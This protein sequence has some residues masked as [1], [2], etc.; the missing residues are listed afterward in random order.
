MVHIID[1]ICGRQR[2]PLPDSLRSLLDTFIAGGGRLLLSTDHFS[3]IDPAWAKQNLHAS[4]YAA[5][6]T[7]S[8]KI[9]STGSV[10]FLPV[11]RNPSPVT[12]LPTFNF[13]LYLEPNEEQLFTCHPEGLKPEKGAVRMAQYMDMR[14]PAAVG[15]SHPQSGAKTLVYGFPLEAVTEF[16]KIYRYSIKWLLEK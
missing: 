7:R 15:Y 2:N 6:A 14:C 10:P 13:Q 9:N 12:P 11:T 16:S 3:A 8:G 1:L 4:F 5:H